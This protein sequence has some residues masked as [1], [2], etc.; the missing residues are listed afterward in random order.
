[1]ESEHRDFDGCHGCFSFP[2]M[3]TDVLFDQDA[4][5]QVSHIVPGT[6]FVFNAIKI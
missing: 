4:V 6:F 5:Y 1:M 2:L 3:V